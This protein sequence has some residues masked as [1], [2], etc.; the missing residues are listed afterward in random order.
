ML[1]KLA[2]PPDSINLP[3]ISLAIVLLCCPLT[4]VLAQEPTRQNIAPEE[5]RKNTNRI[6]TATLFPYRPPASWQGQRFIFL[7]CPKSLENGVYDDFTG[8][9]KRKDY[10]GRIIKVVT[11]SDFSGRLH[12]EF[13]VEGAGEHLRARTIPNKESLKGLLLVED[14]ENARK[15]WVGQTLWCK[16]M[17]LSTYDEQTDALGSIAIKR[18][19]PVKVVE[20][21]PGWD[22]E[23]P[24]RFVLETGD[25]KRGFLDLNL[26]GTNVYSEARQLSRF[27]ASFLTEDPKLSRKWPAHI[28]AAIETNRVLTGMTMEQVKM[29]WGE[30]EQTAR[31]AA[32]E[33]WTYAAG[34]L[35]FSNGKLI[36]I[37]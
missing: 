9:R 37:Q 33:R 17:L 1:S 21:T 25:G 7:S 12:F 35:T 6:E 20:I 36:S 26:S 4:P 13:E 14:L 24:L 3:Q 31:T 15:L 11:V 29:S 5:L 27:E 22:E 34:T 32:G 8:A 30:P 18:Y 19:A 23:K 16:Q 10:A 2:K 28:W